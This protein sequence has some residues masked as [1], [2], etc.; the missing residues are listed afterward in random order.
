MKL[1]AP[2]LF[3]FGYFLGGWG[4]IWILVMLLDR[5]DP[6]FAGAVG[7]YYGIWVCVYLPIAIAGTITLARMKGSYRRKIFVAIVSLIAV[8]VVMFISFFANINWL[9]ILV[10]YISFGIAFWLLE[11]TPNKRMESNGCPDSSS[12]DSL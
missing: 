3:L 11:R 5:G 12:N 1:F 6:K 7:F 4:V 10:E 9:I 8:L 2:F